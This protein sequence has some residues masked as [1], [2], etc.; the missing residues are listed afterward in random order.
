MRFLRSTPVRHSGT[1][2]RGRQGPERAARLGVAGQGMRLVGARCCAHRCALAQAV[3]PPPSLG[4][5]IV[6]D[7]CASIRVAP[8]EKSPSGSSALICGCPST[9]A[10]N[11][12]AASATSDRLRWIQCKRIEVEKSVLR[13]LFDLNWKIS[14]PD[15][16]TDDPNADFNKQFECGVI[17]SHG[18]RLSGSAATSNDQGAPPS[19]DALFDEAGTGGL[20]AS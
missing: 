11:V 6:T 2:V 7:A 9:G 14:G 4:R 10:R 5:K 8:A 15:W 3:W 13:W 19:R 18:H 20:L 17:P 16:L 1:P 12:A